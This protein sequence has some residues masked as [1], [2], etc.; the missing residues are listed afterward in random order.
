VH[1]TVLLYHSHFCFLL[2]FQHFFV[3]PIRRMRTLNTGMNPTFLFNNWILFH[4][5]ILSLILYID[6]FLFSLH[7][8][9]D[10]RFYIYIYKLSLLPEDSG[11]VLLLG[12]KTLHIFVLYTTF[13]PFLTADSCDIFQIK[14]IL[15]ISFLQ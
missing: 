13:F 7:M 3:L 10:C 11:R 9:M 2:H 14:Y 5:Y 8:N 4:L 15:E 12:I 6:I 1:N